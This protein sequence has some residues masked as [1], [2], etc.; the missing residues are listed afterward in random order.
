MSIPL[1]PSILTTPLPL[2]VKAILPFDVDTK[3]LPYSFNMS[4]MCSKEILNE[5]MQHTKAGHVM[6]FNGIPDKDV[7]VPYW[8]EKTYNYLYG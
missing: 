8:M 3:A 6:H 1:E 2:G 5:N 7:S 4:C